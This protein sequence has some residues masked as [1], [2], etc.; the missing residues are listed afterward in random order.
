M[1][2]AVLLLAGF[3]PRLVENRIR[4]F[5][6]NVNIKIVEFFFFFY[7]TKKPAYRAMLKKV[8]SGHE[9]RRLRGGSRRGRAEVWAKEKAKNESLAS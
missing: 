4:K 1:V 5:L 2:M 8:C 6:P 7:P 9:K 3:V